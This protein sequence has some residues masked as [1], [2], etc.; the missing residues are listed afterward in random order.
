MYQYLTPDNIFD[1]FEASKVYTDSLTKMFPEYQRIADALPK[2]G[3]AK[4]LPKTV[5]GTTSSIVKKTPRR[6]VQQLPTGNV[7]GDE[8]WV[9]LVATDITLNEIIP[10]ANSQFEL[11]EKC[12]QSEEGKLTRGYAPIYC[13]VVHEG[14]YIGPDWLNP[15][16]GDV[17]IQP[18]KLSDAD[19]KYIFLRSWWR[20]EDIDALIDGLSKNSK[21][22]PNGGWD[23]ANLR[24][25]KTKEQTKDDQAQT[26]ADK[27][28]A[29]NQRGGIELIIGFQRG[30][31]SSFITFHR[32]S[33]LIVRTK[34]NL[35]P[36]GGIPVNF[37]YCETD[38]T[39]P[40]GRGFVAM[41]YN[42][43]NLMDSDDQMYQHNR[44]LMLA[45]PIIKR[46]VWNKSQAQLIPNAIWD[47]GSNAGNTAE[48]VKIDSTAIA[49]YPALFQLN[50][51]RL[52][53]LLSAPNNAIPSGVGGVQNSKTP[54]GVKQ[55]NANLSIDDNYIAKKFLSAF[56]NW[57][58]NAINI[59][60]ALHTGIEEQ[61]L[62]AETAAKL[63]NIEGFP[64]DELLSDDNKIRINYD[65]PTEVLTFETDPASIKK[66]D[67][68]VQVATVTGLLSTLESTPILQK[69]VP[70]KKVV[71]AWN[72][73]VAASG[74]EDPEDMRISDQEY[75]ENLQKQAAAAEQQAQAEQAANQPQQ[76]PLSESISLSD[77]Y[78]DPNTPADI[79][80]QI[81]QLV[82]LNVTPAD[83]EDMQATQ[84]TEHVKTQASNL[85]AAADALNPEPVEALPVDKPE[86]K[87]LT[88]GAAV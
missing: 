12:W 58:T 1:R 21:D 14:D 55:T 86:P 23:V 35:D 74:I 8:E 7:T 36:S 11:L 25:V 85:N 64:A 71:A 43:Q 66:Q 51:S 62:T 82:G 78:K 9:N 65:D 34:E 75:E 87:K 83:F 19:S 28:M 41:V 26:P 17:F 22:D 59:W 56:G 61:Q 20:E 80:A 60:F 50:Q 29:I 54:D 53:N 67:D 13:P 68:S 57:A 16:W 15:W 33:R 10:H 84:Q 88:A 27:Q 42:T 70:E 38:G 24:E 63:R 73:I 39:N 46:G 52:Y 30:V 48:T 18:G 32:E 76:K 49:Q 77:I 79:K 44:A 40:F 3:I 69:I 72:A 81:I 45:P 31:K 47:L 2:A 5:D 37:N 6:T 4:H